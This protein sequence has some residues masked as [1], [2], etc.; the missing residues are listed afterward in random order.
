[1]KAKCNMT[2]GE[3]VRLGKERYERDLRMLVEP[4]HK[5]RFLV[6]DVVTG[7]YEIADT[8]RGASAQAKARNPDAVLFGVRIGYPTAYRIGRPAGVPKK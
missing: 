8:D 2:P 5:G 7:D 4:I 6:V 3:I 1:M